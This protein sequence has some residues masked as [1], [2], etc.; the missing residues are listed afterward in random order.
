MAHPDDVQEPPDAAQLEGT[1]DLDE[2]AFDPAAGPAPE[3]ARNDTAGSRPGGDGTTPPQA[4]EGADE[5]V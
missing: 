5:G 4:V 1:L 2:T 3:V